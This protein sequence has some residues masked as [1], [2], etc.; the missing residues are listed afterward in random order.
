MR[1]FTSRSA[2]FAYALALGCA[3]QVPAVS[4]TQQTPPRMATADESQTLLTVR[5][6]GAETTIWEWYNS[7][8]QNARIDRVRSLMT[9]IAWVPKR[10]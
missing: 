7:M 3:V 6:A 5:G 10:R 2:A 9:E 4:Q 8:R 1:R